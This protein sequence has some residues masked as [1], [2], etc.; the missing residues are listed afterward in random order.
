[1]RNGLWQVLGFKTRKSIIGD[2]SLLFNL[3]RSILVDFF[4]PR[5]V[6]TGENAGANAD[7][8][9]FRER[10][11]TFFT[12]Y[13]NPFS[14]FSVC[15]LG[16]YSPGGTFSHTTIYRFHRSPRSTYVRLPVPSVDF[17]RQ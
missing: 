10:W 15:R 11:G 17:L 4:K 14:V 9:S 1:M 6:P 7:R 3:S 16:V 13:K 5:I 12:I 2:R 8:A